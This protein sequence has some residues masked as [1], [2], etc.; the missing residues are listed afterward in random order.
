MEQ[1]DDSAVHAITPNVSSRRR[2]RIFCYCAWADRLT[3]TE[4]FLKDRD[5]IDLASRLADA[6]DSALRQ[7]ARL[8]RDWHVENVRALAALQHPAVDFLSAGVLGARGLTDLLSRHRPADE[9]WWFTLTGQQPRHLAGIIGKVLAYLGQAGVRT[10]YYAFDDASRNLECFRE[11]APHLSV[12][13]HD[14]GPLDE[15]ARRALAPECLTIHRSWV[16]NLLP[17]ATPF[18]EAPEEKILFLGSRLGFTPHRRRQVDYLQ[19]RFKDR[20]VAIHDHSVPVDDRLGLRRFKVGFCPEGRMFATTSMSAT[21]TDRPF[22]SGCLGMVPV[23]EDSAA[24]GRLDDLH[25][26]RL[27]R[28][29]PRGDL[30]ALGDACEEAL[31]AD[32]AARRRIYEHFNRHETIGTV[33]ADAIHRAGPVS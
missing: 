13:I 32:P 31:A 21:H 23:S 27:I 10:L 20:M 9:E 11:L 26:A 14:E 24:G 2:A 28:R 7:M 17:F 12:L 5:R 3:E 16:A 15:S 33:V 19:T 6:G 1:N 30:A 29:Y 4:A 18:N 25:Q 22:W 8:D